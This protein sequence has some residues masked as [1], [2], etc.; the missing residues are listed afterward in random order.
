[1]NV[2]TDK[3]AEFCASYFAVREEVRTGVAGSSLLIPQKPILGPV[4]VGTHAGFGRFVLHYIDDTV[5]NS[6][7]NITHQQNPYTTTIRTPL[8]SQGS[9]DTYKHYKRLIIRAVS[10]NSDLSNLRAGGSTT[11]AT[12]SV[13]IYDSENN[14]VQ[15]TNGVVVENDGVES[16]T[17][18]SNFSNF[19]IQVRPIDLPIPHRAKSISIEFV[20]S[21]E[22]ALKILDFALVV[23]TK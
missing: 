1:M 9:P 11:P 6:S 21:T 10:N 3:K 18:P 15:I 17:V 4:L 5:N 2:T 23:D 19:P 16:T 22:H 7:S 12:M 8:L 14:Q 20:S 13:R